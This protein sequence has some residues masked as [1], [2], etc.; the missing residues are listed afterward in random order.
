[1][2]EAYERLLLD[3]FQGDASLFARADEV[4]LAWGIIDPIRSRL[5]RHPPAAAGNR[6]S[7][8]CGARPTP[9]PGWT[10][11]AGSGSTSAP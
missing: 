3:V 10:S 9:P 7:P 11:K 1:M 4:E 2:P 5:A 8:A 6:T